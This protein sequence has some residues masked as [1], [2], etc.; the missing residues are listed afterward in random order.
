[1]IRHS[2]PIIFFRKKFKW[3]ILCLFIGIIII[4]LLSGSS[5]H[6]TDLLIPIDYV[7]LPEGFSISRP[8]LNSIEVHVKGKK[9]KIENLPNIRLRYILDLSRVQTG[10]NTIPTKKG[11]ISLPEGI[12][13]VS[14]NPSFIAV[15]I[16]HK[17]KRE[18]PV[19]I[20]LTGK[21][22]YGY[23]VSD[24]LAAPASVILYGPQTV[25]G[26]QD[27][28]KTKP[29]D[30]SGVKE[31]FKKEVTLDLAE[32]I[33]TFSD[34]TIIQ[35]QVSIEQKI[36]IREFKSIPIKGKHTKLRY[37]INPPSINITVK[38]PV[39]IIEK[40]QAGNDI[41]VY[42]DLNGLKP[43]TYVK[44]AVINLPVHTVLDSVSPKHFTIKIRKW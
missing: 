2:P 41:N 9:S 23:V 17:I 16:E 13:V 8:P 33:S 26:S 19:L 11:N 3:I 31:S 40:L 7:R 18:L 14:L 5:L 44:R 24:I 30:I 25:L 38:G 35:A 34:S 4:L 29:I 15:K 28:I 42:I 37:S 10:I 43:G 21:P 6:E 12:S 32:G 36:I 27:K 39:N 1:M 22:A 20:S